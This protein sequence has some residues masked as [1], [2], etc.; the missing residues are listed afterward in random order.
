LRPANG[1]QRE[2]HSSTGIFF[3]AEQIG[4]PPLYGGLLRWSGGVPTNA[5]HVWHEYAGHRPVTSF[6]LHA[7]SP[8]IGAADQFLD[9]ILSISSWIIWLSPNVTACS[10]V[11]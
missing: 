8:F 7:E 6:E 2:V 9:R 3:V 10:N 11:R 4:L 5:D 1:R